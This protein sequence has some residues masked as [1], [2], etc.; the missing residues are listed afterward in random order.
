MQNMVVHTWFSNKWNT[1]KVEDA[2]KQIL[3]LATTDKEVKS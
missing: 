3:T 1:V 2:N